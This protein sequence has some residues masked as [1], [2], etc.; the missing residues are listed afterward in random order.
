MPLEKI[1]TGI[2]LYYESQG[3]GE[4]LVCIPG[5]GF[6]GNVWM[7]TQVEALSPSLQ[8]IVHDPRGC[9]RSTH[10][11]G[12]YTIDQM[13]N[14]VAALLEHLNV[15][16]AHIIGH[17][18]GGDVIAAAARLIPRDRISGL[19][20]VETYK[21]LGSGRTPEQVEA[22][23]ATLRPHFADSVRSLVRSLFVPTSD[24]T[25]VEWVAT[26]MSSAPPRVA[27]SAIENSF[28]Y[29]REITKAL[30]EVKL[31]TVALNSDNGPT[32]TTS[33]Q[34]YGV[35]V[36]IVPGFG[37]FLMMENPKLFNAALEKIIDKLKK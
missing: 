7:E 21:K 26:D 37:H 20:M 11:K 30:E 34:R 24:T 12:V 4:A 3:R 1:S 6:S 23:V 15:R 35:D 22:F 10:F 16:S 17:S 36:V 25:L 32:D 27:L 13:A 31:P 19:V 18:M 33:M 9:G 8:V 5:T 29:S 28:N 2:D 14:D